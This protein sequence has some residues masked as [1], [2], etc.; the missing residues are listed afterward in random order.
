MANNTV[1]N[2]LFTIASLHDIVENPDNP[3]YKEIL[4]KYTKCNESNYFITN[5]EAFSSIYTYLKKNY[6]NEYYYK[7][8][9]LNR[10]LLGAHSISTTT[11][12]TQIPISASKADFVMINGKAVVYEIKTELD[13]LE[14]LES[15]IKNYY[16]AF[17]HVCVVTCDEYAEVLLSRFA[18]LPVGIYTISDSEYIRHIKEPQLNNADLDSSVIFKVLNKSEYESIIQ[19]FYGSLPQT[20]QVMYYRECRKLF[21]DIPKEKQYTAFLKEL[22]KR[23]SIQDKQMFLDVPYE[24]KALVY[25]SHFSKSD[26]ST[27]NNFLSTQIGG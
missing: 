11:A 18:D 21:L 26:Y 10:L 9:I 17:D 25:F 4:E 24:L 16:K 1:L 27:L 8:T 13:N 3:V 23:N 14:R 5:E 7:N 19:S 20:T 22:K 12:L 15:Q 2:R 6:R